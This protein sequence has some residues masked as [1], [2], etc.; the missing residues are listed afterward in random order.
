MTISNTTE[1]QERLNE[2]LVILIEECAEVQQ[3]ASKILRFGIESSWLNEA[4]KDRLESELGDLLGM[5][6]E[7]CEN[8]FLDREL[9]DQASLKKR[10]KI[11]LWM[12]HY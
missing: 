12:N 3:M 6:D 5:V 9:I 2:R 7:L 4:N 11:K 10:E 1:N 8:G